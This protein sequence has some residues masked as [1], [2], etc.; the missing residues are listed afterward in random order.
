MALTIGQT[1]QQIHESLSDYIESAYHVSETTLV[2]Q[3]KRILSKSGV[4]HQ[5]PYI[6][7]TPRYQTGTRFRDLGLSEAAMKIFSA[8]F[9]P[10]ADASLSRLIYDPPYQHQGESVKFTLVDNRSIVVMT[11]TGSGKTECFLLPILGKLASEAHSKGEEF[12]SSSAMR[13]M[14]LY[15][16]NALVN[17]QLGRLRL[18]FGDPRIVREFK[19]WSGRPAR[20]ARYTSRTLYP[21]VRDVRKD[22]SKLSPIRDF[23]VHNLELA[24]S[25]NSSQEEAER[26]VRELRQR[27]KWPAKPDLI[28]WYGRT[29]ERWKD[30]NGEFQRCVT[31]PDDAELLTRHEVQTAPPDVLVT[32]YSMLEYMLMRPLERPIFELT[33]EWL[34]N[35]PDERFLLVIDEA[36]LY[37]GASGT[38]VAL[39]IR[40]LTRRLGIGPERLQV[41]C[42]SASLADADSALSFAT[43]LTGKTAD[44]FSVVQG[45]LAL[46]PNEEAGTIQDARALSDINLD[47]FYEADSDDVRL[48]HISAFLRYR[49][50]DEPW[51]LQ[52]SLYDALCSFGPMRKVINMTMK[53][54]LPVDE[55]GPALFHEVTSDMSELATTNLIALGSMAKRDENGPS[56]LPCRMHSFYRGLPGLWIC[57]D[58]DCT[59]LPIEQ[60]GGP[61]GQ[62]FNQP[63]YICECGARVQELYTCR[64]CGTAYARAYTDDIVDPEF[65]WSE[66]GTAFHTLTSQ[67]DEL[68]PIDLLL[69][70]PNPAFRDKV[71]P[72]EYD[73]VTGRLNPMKLGERSRQVYL[74]KDREAPPDGEDARAETTLGEFNPCAVC[75]RGAGFGRSSVQDHQTKGDQPFQALVTKQIQV[76]PPSRV[77]KSRFAPLRGRKV[78]VFSDSRQTAARLA[79]NIQTYSTQD[80]LRPLLVSGYGRL[81]SSPVAN[82][83][84]SLEDLYLAA[85]I[86]AN[87]LEVRIYPEIRGDESFYRANHE[88]RSAI[89]NGNGKIE[90]ADLLSLLVRMRVEAPPESL[91]RGIVNSLTD[92]Y[93]GLES[94]ALASVIETARHTARVTALPEIPGIAQSNE[95]K[96]AL[97]RLWIRCWNR[98]GVWFGHTPSSWWSRD[99][100]SHSGR[101]RDIQRFLGENSAIRLFQTKWLPELLALFTEP[102][103]SNQNRI[104]GIELSLE[105]GGEWSYC[106][107]CRTTQR[108]FPNRTKCVNCGNDAV[109]PIDPDNDPVFV[110][111]KGYYRASTLQ[112]LGINPTPPMALIAAEHTAQLNT[113]QENEVFSKAE[114][115]ELLFQD[116][117]LG[118]QGATQE[119]PAI[120]VLSCTTTME[121]G[122]DI[123]ALSGVSLR[124]MPP[125]RANYQQRSGRAGRRGDAIATVTA[126]GSADSHDEHYFVHPDQMI[127]GS[128]DTPTLTLDN[129]VIAQRHITAFLLQRY[130]AERIPE[131]EPEAQPHLF[132]V[133]GTVTDFRNPT[134]DINR[135]DLETWLRSNEVELK[136][137]V[138]EWLPVEIDDQER[139][140]LLNHL[141][142]ETLQS[143]DEAIEYEPEQHVDATPISEDSSA[144]EVQDELDEERPSLNATSEN[145]LDRLLYRGVLPRFAFPTDVASFHVFSQNESTYRPVFEYTPSQGL[146]IAL[147]QYAPGKDVWIDGKLWTS[148][149]IYSPI[150][151]DRYRAWE[152]RRI[153]FECKVCHYADTIHL[154]DGESGETRNCVACGESDTFGPGM[155]WMR[156]PGFAHP[157]N[158]SEGTSPDD[159]PA[160]SFATRAKLTMPTPTDQENWTSLNDS[161]RVHSTRQHL[162]VTNRGPREEGY[163][164][165]TSCGLIEPTSLPNGQISSSHQKPFPTRPNDRDCQGQRITRGLVLGTDFISD[166]LLISIRVNSPLNLKPG[167]LSTDVALRTVSEALARAAC[168]KLEID[169]SELQAEYRPALTV[170]GQEGLEAEIYLY[171]TLPGGAGFAQSVATL[172]LSVFEDALRLLDECPEGCDKS[173]YRCLRSYKNK[174]EHHLLDRHIGGSLLRSIIHGDPPAISPR[175]VS[176]STEMLFEDIKRQ[177]IEDLILKRDYSFEVPGLGKVM[178]PIYARNSY[179]QEFIIGLHG[180]L[181]PDYIHDEQLQEI[182]E[183]CPT[184][185]VLLRDELAVHLNLPSTTKGIMDEL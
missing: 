173:C 100:R 61:A 79:P 155:Y 123:G 136:R 78:L 32:N 129:S 150:S 39:L 174:F 52:K 11:G 58:S 16:M 158:K 68:A 34:E 28:N 178:A 120:D 156:P 66:P 121:V 105:I 138:D 19:H 152:S 102:V 49:Q 108:P 99:I 69:E 36:H 101:F 60:R 116:V 74:R 112:A 5:R 35:N 30:A 95:E 126:F 147:S 57:M 185:P 183:F 132:D 88:V 91:L 25:E 159:Q 73:I 154:T 175:R 98:I 65:L 20:F 80:A 115:Y 71:E 85:L 163:T 10:D 6:E 109:Q 77:K 165:C 107:L 22:Q 170:E 26:L 140:R 168:A 177:N 38:E 146:P 145:L 124:N 4:I 14:V 51:E 166:V 151:D 29:R 48:S 144:L 23:Y 8:V 67:Y 3:R 72:A 92:R 118:M 87:E 55:L 56:L 43:Q 160:R 86:A 27:G 47:A 15:P 139:L 96:L 37:R 127:R 180:P 13:A 89:N 143:I 134:S 9:E 122:I 64:N 53:E 7:S 21:G 171:D 97:A 84:A 50:I 162:L 117:Y 81:A 176:K 59:M 167:L 164:Y 141:T 70:N 83:L 41:I 148:G 114:E 137:E 103:S 82:S 110:A 104:R 119:R 161:V 24:G 17:D 42:T 76:Q 45:T 125:S 111:R 130:H 2:D 94:L 54:A 179:G 46:H 142:V 128:T 90:D 40:R 63:R 106:Q 184:I 133:L 135:A 172:G 44:D 153:Y 33:R 113:A 131:I 149:A 12:G 18:L 1:A 157:V 31:L 182:K 181:T 169:P 75:G 93:F 62:L